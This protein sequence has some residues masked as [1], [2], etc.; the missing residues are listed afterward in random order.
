MENLFFR[1]RLFL[2]AV[3]LLAFFPLSCAPAAPK[4]SAAPVIDRAVALMNHGLDNQAMAAFIEALHH[5]GSTETQRAEALFYLGRIS[6]DNQ[7]ADVAIKDWERLTREYPRSR[8]AQEVNQQMA[9]LQ[10]LARQQ[11]AG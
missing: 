1:N 4:A 6:F 11:Q 10:A 8:R 7:K 5:P 9:R 2:V 3:P